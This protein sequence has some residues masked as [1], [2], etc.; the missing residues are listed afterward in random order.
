MKIGIIGAGRLGSAFIAGL[1]KY[2]ELN[3]FDP[4]SEKLVR[5]KAVKVMPSNEAL[6]LNSDIILVAVKPKDIMELIGPIAPL[7]GT[8]LLVSVAAGVSIKKLEMLGVKNIIRLMPNIGIAV[9]EGM[10][11]YSIAPGS[12]QFENMFVKT[13]EKLGRCLNVK[14]EYLDAITVC[15]GS[16][17]AF[18]AAFADAMVKE[19]I[20]QG[21]DESVAKIAVAQTLVGTGKLMLGGKSAHEIIHQV[22]SP[23]G[24]TEEGLRIL[25]SHGVKDKIAEAMRFA[26]KKTSQLTK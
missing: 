26:I 11:A 6:V 8:R 22:A 16:G 10:L 14:E 1:S 24:V 7:L 13:F 21:L 5:L 12:S 18:V 3:V 9:E 20:A 4:N 2:Y 25:E 15:S 23:G 19:A 17:P